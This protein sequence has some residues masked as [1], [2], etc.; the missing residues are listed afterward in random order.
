MIRYLALF[1]LALAMAGCG[2][3]IDLGN[4]SSDR[5]YSVQYPD[6]IS[7]LPSETSTV[8]VDE[9][10]FSAG[11][12]GE[13]IVVRMPSGEQL[14]MSGVAW[15]GHPADMIRDYMVSAVRARGNMRAYG[16]G[17]LDIQVGCRLGVRLVDYQLRS[18]DVQTETDFGQVQIKMEMVLIQL[19]TG[20]II[21]EFTVSENVD[22][23]EVGS[24]SIIQS[25]MNA[26][27]TVSHRAA[28]KLKSVSQQC[29]L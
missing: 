22:V 2:P 13:S 4:K 7:E 24:D 23:N 18:P 14:E 15:A 12:D 19:K 21:S 17:S 29:S 10:T 27:Y 8:F 1:L 26:T 28:I 9:F 20:M 11:L 25:F 16:E 5:I 6:E 3:I